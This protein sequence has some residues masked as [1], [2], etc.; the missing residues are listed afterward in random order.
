MV[1]LN[2]KHVMEAKGVRTQK[3]LADRLG[4]TP[5]NFSAMLRRNITLESLVNIAKALDVTVAELLGEP[6]PQIEKGISF[7]CPHCN[8]VIHVG[9]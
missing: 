3:E 2:I 5:S 4:I 1:Q 9:K 6:E 7:R 8:K